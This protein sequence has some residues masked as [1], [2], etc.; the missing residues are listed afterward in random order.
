MLCRSLNRGQHASSPDPGSEISREPQPLLAA[1]KNGS[2]CL[3]FFGGDPTLKPQDYV[4]SLGLQ[5]GVVCSLTKQVHGT[6]VQQQ[7]WTQQ[8]SQ[9]SVVAF[10]S[11]LGSGSYLGASLSLCYLVTLS[12]SFLY[13]QT[14][15]TRAT[16]LRM[17]WFTIHSENIYPPKTWENCVC[18]VCCVSKGHLALP[19]LYFYVLI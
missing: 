3:F 12:D 11:S 13:L 16:L 19:Y 18:I 2:V 10:T 6:L 9:T 5:L 7:Q 8:C 15:P 17:W 1:R 14:G 4:N